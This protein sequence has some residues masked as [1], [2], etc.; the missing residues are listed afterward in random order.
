[1]VWEG[2]VVLQKVREA[3]GCI[4]GLY[5]DGPSFHA[6]PLPPARGAAG[7][8]ALCPAPARARAGRGRSGSARNML[9]MVEPHPLPEPA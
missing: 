4:E 7:R 3:Q 5:F 2:L 1:M 6:V 9:R 8:G